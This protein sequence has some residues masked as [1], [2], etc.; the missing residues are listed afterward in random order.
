MKIICSIGGGE[1]GGFF[2]GKERPVETEAID[3]E[4]IALTKKQHPKVLFLPTASGDSKGYISNFTNYYTSLGCEVD[5]LLLHD[6]FV[7]PTVLKKKILSTDL[8]YVGGGNTLKMMK[9]RKKVGLIPLLQQAHKKGIILSGLSAGGICWLH[10][11]MSDSRQ[12]SNKDAGFIIVKGLDFAPFYFCPHFDRDVKRKEFLP[13]FIKK[14][15]KKWIV[16][17]EGTAFLIKRKQRKIIK[18]KP[19]AHAYLGFHNRGEII[20]SDLKTADFQSLSI[21]S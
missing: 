21:F 15:H 6:K 17:E 13:D 19:Q 16:L 2:D 18:S 8:I 11:G 4:L 7:D 20:Y 10:G 14:T 9:L 12:F 1:I 5:T 3:R